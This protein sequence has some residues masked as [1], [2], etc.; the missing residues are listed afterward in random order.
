MRDVAVRRLRKGERT[1]VLQVFDGL[2]DR[3]RLLR[4]HSSKPRLP[5]A[6]LDRLV[7]VGCCGR[8]AVAAVE[9]ES[10]RSV[11]I[12]RFVRDRTEPDAAEVAFAVVDVWQGRGVGKRLLAELVPLARAAG[13]ARFRASVVA[14][15][16]AALALLRRAGRIAAAEYVD[17]AFEL[18]V[19]LHDEQAY[20]HAA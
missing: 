13:I 19:E 10:G 18:V 20:R 4:F 11:G 7:D 2:S 8:E 1:P 14:G 12:A 9:S 6:E 16:E 5:D 17:G 3:S 15:N